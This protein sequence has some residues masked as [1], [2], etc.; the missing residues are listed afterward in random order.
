MI[1]CTVNVNYDK[2]C[3]IVRKT[4]NDSF[5]FADSSVGYFNCKVRFNFIHIECCRSPV[6]NE[7]VVSIIDYDNTVV[8]CRY[9][10]QCEVCS[11]VYNWSCVVY[12]INIDCHIA[13]CIYVADCYIDYLFI[14]N[15]NIVYS[16]IN[17][18]I[19]FAYNEECGCACLIIV[20]SPIISHF[21][22]IC[23]CSQVVYIQCS[24]NIVSWNSRN[25]CS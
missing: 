8:S 3:C 19:L 22:R 1:F 9:F 20:F 2:S 23:S 6:T 24:F 4:Y 12:A 17:S 10:V 25:A 7:V 11:S 18:S 16:D 5:C 15:S 13:G 14:C 21:N